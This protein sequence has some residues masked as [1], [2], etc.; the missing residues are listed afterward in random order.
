MC[1]FIL[2]Q[3]H[4]FYI[5]EGSIKLT[6]VRSLENNFQYF[7]FDFSSRNSTEKKFENWGKTKQN[8]TL[9]VVEVGVVFF[10]NETQ[11]KSLTFLH[12]YFIATCCKEWFPQ[13]L[14]RRHFSS[15]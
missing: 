10:I 7:Q 5:S 3:K 11:S 15:V 2:D 4:N 1:M 12:G 9:M 8:Q 13:L 6:F 14:Q